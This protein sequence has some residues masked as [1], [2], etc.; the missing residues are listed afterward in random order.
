MTNGL[1]RD[2]GFLRA[3]VEIE[4][5]RFSGAGIRCADGKYI[6]PDKAVMSSMLRQHYVDFHNGEFQLTPAGRQVVR[7]V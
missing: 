4:G 5:E 1:S 3:Y 7:T 2:V 6:V